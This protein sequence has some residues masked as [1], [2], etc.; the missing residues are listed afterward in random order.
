M[1]DRLSVMGHTG[2]LSIKKGDFK[3]TTRFMGEK[4]KYVDGAALDRSSGSFRVSEQHSI[5]RSVNNRK[6][7]PACGVCTDWQI[8]F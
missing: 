1:R 7:G 2:T 3:I 4:E 8:P 5:A 6:F